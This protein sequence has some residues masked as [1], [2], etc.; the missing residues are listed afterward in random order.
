M[1]VFT[2]VTK[3]QLSIWLQD[4]PIGTLVDLQGISSGIENTNYLVTTTLGK[5]ILTL[6]EKL[7]TAELPFYLNLMAHL[8]HRGI[9]CPNPI[10]TREQTLLGELNGKPASIVTFLPGKSLKHP[11][12]EQCAEIGGMLARMHLAGLS[13]P[14]KMANPRGLE[15]WN[16][17]TK[18]V[19][20]FL[21]REEQILLNE[22]LQFQVLHQTEA[23][24]QGVIH[25][26]LFRDNVLFTDTS[27]GG[28]ID[29]YFACNDAFLY[30]L[31][32][33]IND[34]CISEDRV[35]DEMHAQALLAAYHRIRPLVNEEYTAWPRMLR[36]GAL[37]FWISRLYDYH[38]PR[39][40]ELTHKKDPMHFR[41]ILKHHLANH[42]KLMQIWIN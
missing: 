13:Y 25:A 26:D 33:T 12:A 14:M 18:E 41:E 6:F 5:Y 34:W 2:P 7:T 17:A 20:P 31:A 36:A 21:T 19:M 22:E 3:E 38:L 16:T 9:P 27:I 11:T 28:I 30:D 24:P 32:I 23:L 29:F 1:S 35:L 8:S 39:E 42:S 15:W 37:R 10:A 4:Y 40:G